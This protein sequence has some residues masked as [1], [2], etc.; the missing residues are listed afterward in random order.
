MSDW[1]EAPCETSKL[2]GWSTAQ[3]KILLFHVKTINMESHFWTSLSEEE[4]ILAI[5]N[6]LVWYFCDAFCANM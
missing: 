6:F 5:G 1:F 2:L 4:N 3:C